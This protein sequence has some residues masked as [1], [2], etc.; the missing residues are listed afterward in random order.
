[1]RRGMLMCRHA[2][3][4]L[5]VLSVRR[6]GSECC[7]GRGVFA[8]LRMPGS[9]WS[10]QQLRLSAAWQCVMHEAW[11]GALH[12]EAPLVTGLQGCRSVSMEPPLWTHKFCAGLQCQPD[13]LACL[14]KR[15]WLAPPASTALPIIS[16]R[17]VVTRHQ[18]QVQMHPQAISGFL[19]SLVLRPTV[20]MDRHY[21]RTGEAKVGLVTM[22]ILLPLPRW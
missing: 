18:L 21:V 13:R 16:I 2:A 6:A 1:L 9:C 8:G 14:P 5:C 22:I 3:Y 19:T 4:A 15:C 20:L 10:R 12:A 17:A 11:R 7:I